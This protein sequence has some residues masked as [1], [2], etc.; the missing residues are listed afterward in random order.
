MRAAQRGFVE[1]VRTLLNAQART[2]IRDLEGHG[3]ELK[4][5]FIP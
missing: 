1:S 4:F 2:D 5:L 3:I